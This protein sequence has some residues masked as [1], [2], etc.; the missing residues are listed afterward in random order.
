MQKRRGRPPIFDKA[1]T[2][3]EHQRRW[4]ERVRAK[5]PPPRPMTREDVLACVPT[6]EDVR[7]AFVD[8]RQR[9]K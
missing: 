1:M 3:T 8:P 5:A 9:A 2:A 7:A 6:L 4:R